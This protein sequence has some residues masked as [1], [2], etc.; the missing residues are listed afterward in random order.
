M[1]ARLLVFLLVLIAS[2]AFGQDPAPAKAGD[3]APE[4]DWTKIVQSPESAKYQPSLMGQYTVL[5]FLPPVT[6]NVQAVDHWNELIA[7]FRDQP[8][9]FV[10][11]ASEKWSAVQPFL[12][13]HPLNGWLLI[14]EKNEAA[15][16]YGCEMGG[17]AIVDP[18]GKIVGFHAFPRSTAIGGRSRREGRGN[19]PRNCGRSGIQAAP[20][21]QGS[22]GNRTGTMGTSARS[23]EAGYLAVV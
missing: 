4:I 2:V 10:W 18:F 14:D 7:K 16:S 9:Q 17:D 11:I 5:Q 13:E 3:R 15:R 6:P 23:R 1:S 19:R 12:R 20:R 8:L 22:A 21:R